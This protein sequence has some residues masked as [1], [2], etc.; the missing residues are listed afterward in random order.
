[1]FHEYINY[2]LITSY[3]RIYML[4]RYFIFNFL[5]EF[6]QNDYL[7]NTFKNTISLILI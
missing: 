5:K 3:F 4:Y 7:M 6:K 2:E 1:M